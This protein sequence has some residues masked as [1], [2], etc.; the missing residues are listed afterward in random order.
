MAVHAGRL[1][2]GTLPSGRVLALEAGKA[3]S[4]DRALEPGW[5]HVAAV[6]TS[7]RLELYVDGERVATSSA[8][9][10]ADYD[11]TCARPLRIGFGEHDYFN[12]RLR[13]LRLYGRAL[14]EAEIRALLKAR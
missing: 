1:F 4:Y 5:R 11:L 6:R 14:T 10:A 8:F 2:C 3:V 7:G 12:G 9:D 13:D